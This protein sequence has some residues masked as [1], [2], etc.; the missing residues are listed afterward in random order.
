MVDE[1]GG[2]ALHGGVHNV[3]V[4]Y[5]EHVAADALQQQYKFKLEIITIKQR[6]RFF[7]V[8][9]PL[10]QY[11]IFRTEP[12]RSYYSDTHNIFVILACSP[13]E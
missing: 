2:T 12:S 9:V 8:F 11:S 5:T 3:H 13:Q 6:C 7:L 4:I 10:M 1:S